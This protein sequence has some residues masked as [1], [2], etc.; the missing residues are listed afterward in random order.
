[1]QRGSHEDQPG[2][3]VEIALDQVEGTPN[4]QLPGMDKIGVGIRN[5]FEPIL[6]LLAVDETG[7]GLGFPKVQTHLVQRYRAQPRVKDATILPKL[8]EILEDGLKDLLTAIGSIAVLE[9]VATAPAIYD[10]AIQCTETLPGRRLQGAGP[11]QQAERSGENRSP[12]MR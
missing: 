1:V 10:W 11:L 7:C 3:C 9:A 4:H 12:S 8:A 6:K 5:R 2:L